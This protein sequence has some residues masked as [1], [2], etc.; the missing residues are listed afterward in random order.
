MW[1]FIAY[2]AIAIII[3]VALTPKVRPRAPEA[4]Q[5]ID[6]PQA[7]EG[8]PQC[9]IFGDVWVDDWMVMAVGDYRTQAIEKDGGG[10]K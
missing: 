2:V 8:T 6:F 1:A 10:K 3:S 5:D 4:F 7:E 9:V